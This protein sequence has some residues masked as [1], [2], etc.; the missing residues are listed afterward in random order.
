M[1]KAR[2]IPSV[3]LELGT[4]EELVQKEGGH[5]AALASRQLGTTG[6]AAAAAATA[7][8]EVEEA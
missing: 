7:P 6:A 2:T 4:H 1:L 5:Y 8:A 3:V